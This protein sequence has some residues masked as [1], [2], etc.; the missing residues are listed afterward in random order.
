MR[1]IEDLIE[2]I[3]AV[4]GL[5]DEPSAVA[6][7]GQNVVFGDGDSCSARASGPTR[8]TRSAGP[9]RVRDGRRA[10]HGR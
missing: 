6:G 1:T 8:S 5:P 9:G 3:P 4:R 2:E 7:C 10:A